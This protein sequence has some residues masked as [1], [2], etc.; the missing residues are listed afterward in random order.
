MQRVQQL[1]DVDDLKPAAD[2]AG[3]LFGG[4][5]LLFVR[6]VSAAQIDSVRRVPG[7]QFARHKTGQRRGIG[8]AGEHQQHIC[9]VGHDAQRSG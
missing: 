1:G 8:S 9:G 3:N 4:L 6:R 5:D 2:P 7:R